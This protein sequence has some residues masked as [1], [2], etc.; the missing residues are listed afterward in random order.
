MIMQHTHMTGNHDF[1]YHVEYLCFGNLIREYK[2]KRFAILCF[3]LDKMVQLLS[4]TF[5]EA[6]FKISLRVGFF[7]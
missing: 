2:L 7:A 3:F 6:K 4:G 5:R 1:D